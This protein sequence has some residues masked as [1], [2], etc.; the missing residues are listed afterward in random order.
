M[1]V[2]S[3]TSYQ[4][5]WYNPA[6]VICQGINGSRPTECNRGDVRLVN[7]H[8]E[9]EGRVEACAYGY[10][11]MAC[12]SNWNIGATRLVCKQLGFPMESMYIHV[13]INNGIYTTIYMQYLRTTCPVVHLDPTINCLSLGFPVA[14]EPVT[15]VNA[16][17]TIRQIATIKEQLEYFAKVKYYTA[18]PIVVKLIQI[19]SDN[20]VSICITYNYYATVKQYYIHEFTIDGCHIIKF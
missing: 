4:W 15:S 7:G 3:G 12:D 19:D 6:G 1:S 2:S 9:T 16:N 13:N 18:S 17:Y 5:P 10:W 14:V 8:S 20:M 11:A